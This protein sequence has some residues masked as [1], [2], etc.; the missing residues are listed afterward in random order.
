M[1][2]EALQIALESSLIDRERIAGSS[3]K[4]RKE[5]AD[6][7]RRA[8]QAYASLSIALER[9]EIN[10][11]ARVALEEGIADHEKLLS[12]ARESLATIR[13]YSPSADLPREKYERLLKRGI[14]VRELR[15]QVLLQALGK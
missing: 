4:N 12:E 2:K 14:K 7:F 3:S 13:E 6:D 8:S 1:V 5:H 9:E 10:D 11:A 15:L